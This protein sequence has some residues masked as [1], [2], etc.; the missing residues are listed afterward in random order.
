MTKTPKQDELTPEELADLQFE[1]DGERFKLLAKLS[2]KIDQVDPEYVTVPDRLRAMDQSKFDKLAESMA[3]IP[4]DIRDQIKGTKLDKGVYLDSIKGLE[5][6]EQRAQVK[7]DLAE[8]DRL[9]MLDAKIRA[10]NRATAAVGRALHTVKLAW[11]RA[12]AEDRR[13]IKAWV[14]EQETD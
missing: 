10:A 1:A 2:L 12:S 8:H 9:D 13:R 3:T 6:D 5:A 11:H 4:P 7:A 14:L